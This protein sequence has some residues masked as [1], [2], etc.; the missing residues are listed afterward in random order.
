MKRVAVPTLM[1][2]LALL[3]ESCS[4]T[5]NTEFAHL[6]QE[7]LDWQ[8]NEKSWSISQ[9]LA[10][11]NAYYRYYIPVFRG[12]ISNSRF[13]DP[14]EYFSSSPLGIAVSS[15]VMLG[16]VKNVKRKLKSTKEYNPLINKTLSLDNVIQEYCNHVQEFKAVLKESAVINLRKTKCPLSLRP[17]VKLN[18]GDAFIF[19]A[20]HNERHIEQMK[21]ILVMSKFPK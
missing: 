19:T 17:V 11:L 5:V 13:K 14:Q 15:S 18:M 12:K 7:Q 3:V 8:P 21:K 10:H 2:K 20:Y 4:E 16:K 1:R 9:C 6:R